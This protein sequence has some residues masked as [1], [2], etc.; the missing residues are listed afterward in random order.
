MEGPS[1]S[2]VFIDTSL[3]THLAM[4]VSGADTVSDLKKKIKVEHKACFPTLGEILVNAVKVKRKGDF[5]HLADSMHVRSAFNGVKKNWFLSVD[6]SISSVYSDGQNMLNPSSSGQPVLL[7]ITSKPSSDRLDTAPDD[8]PETVPRKPIRNEMEM[9]KEKLVFDSKDLSGEPE[10]IVAPDQSI[11]SPKSSEPQQASFTEKPVEPVQEKDIEM[12][13]V[14]SGKEYSGDSAED[15]VHSCPLVVREPDHSKRGFGQN[16]VTGG[17]EKAIV[18]GESVVAS[19][20][21]EL[22]ASTKKRKTSKRLKESDGEKCINSFS[23]HIESSLIGRSLADL[24]KVPEG[25]ESQNKLE[26]RENFLS[27]ARGGETMVMA[28]A[29]PLDMH[30]TKVESSQQVIEKNM[31]I[32]STEEKT[33]KKS[34]KSRRSIV[35]NLPSVEMKDPNSDGNDPLV[36]SVTVN[37]TTNKQTSQRGPVK[38]SSCASEGNS[39]GDPLQLTMNVDLPSNDHL[40]KGENLSEARGGETIGLIA[41]P[42][43]LD[44]H[45][46]KVE[47][48][49]Q[50]IEEEAKTDSIGEKT[51]KKRKKSR[52]S[53]GENL[54]LVEM[55]DPN[56]DAFE[57][58]PMSTTLND[59]TNEHTGIMKPTKAPSHTSEGNNEGGPPQS[60]INVDLPSGD[61]L[62]KG[63][64]NL[65]PARGGEK[66]VRAAAIEPL[67]M[68]GT[69]AESSQQII[70][71]ELNFDCT[72]EKTKKKRKK[73]RR[74]TGKNLPLMETKDPK[75]DAFEPTTMSTTLNDTTNEHTRYMEPMKAPSHTSE[76]NNEG[77]LPQSIIKVDLPSGDPLDKG[78]NK[79]SQARGGET[80]VRAAPVEPLDVHG[81]EAE[82]S[83]Q[84]IEKVN[85]ETAEKKKTKKK[86]KK[87][88][89]SAAE[90]LPSVEMKDP[91]SKTNDPLPISATVDET[92]NGHISYMKP[93]EAPSRTTEGN[94]KGDPAQ[95]IMN[96]DLHSGDHLAKGGNSLSQTRGGET[97]VRAAAV[98]PLDV[99]RTKAESL[100]QFVDKEMN[101]EST[102]ENTN[103]KRKKSPRSTVENLPSV[104]M[105]DPDSDANDPPPIS[106]TMKTMK[107]P[108]HTYEG[109]NEGDLPQ[110]I[111][112]VDIPSGDHLDEVNNH[113][114]A[115]IE[116]DIINFSD[117]FAPRQLQQE[118]LAPD[119]SVVDGGTKENSA[120]RK[121]K[122]KRRKKAD[123]TVDGSLSGLQSSLMSSGPQDGLKSPTGPGST[124]QTLLSS[125][126][127]QFKIIAEEAPGTKVI[128]V[129]PNL[130]ED[131]ET[132]AA[133]G[134][135]LTSI[136]GEVVDTSERKKSLLATS[137]AIFNDESSGSSAEAEG[138]EDS[139]AST[140]T[141]SDKLLSDYSDG[142]SN[143]NLNSPRDGNLSRKDDG[144]S[145]MKKSQSLD[146]KDLTLD[147]ILRSSSRYK[148]AKLAASQSQLGDSESQPLEFQEPP[149]VVTSRGLGDCRQL[150]GRCILGRPEPVS[151]KPAKPEP[152]DHPLGAPHPVDLVERRLEDVEEDPSDGRDEGQQQCEPA[153]VTL[154]QFSD[155]LG[156][157]GRVGM[158]ECREDSPGDGGAG[159]DL[160]RLGEVERRPAGRLRKVGLRDG[161]AGMSLG[162]EEELVAKHLALSM[163]MVDTVAAIG[164]GCF[165]LELSVSLSS[166]GGGEL[167]SWMVMRLR[168]KN[169]K[170]WCQLSTKTWKWPMGS[171]SLDSRLIRRL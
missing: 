106:A 126:S 162:C 82:S 69:K 117:Y 86:R 155:L 81:T 142:D 20:T 136:L 127:D 105:E 43:H 168:S 45:R 121:V 100:E 74:S 35:E 109:K 23:E 144:G 12:R 10:I 153:V 115:V 39:G 145:S 129:T 3:G 166:S 71:K 37:E 15:G 112:D 1:P 101:I 104:D 107:A 76:G 31:D 62:D 167:K 54:P 34:K 60:I 63:E 158:A 16:K 139:N 103:K 6:A 93:M 124:D 50:I 61:H 8:Q 5:Y 113:V 97:M 55:K 19:K 156:C 110:S 169:G 96:V 90:N 171:C 160:G 132:S 141:P 94:N 42:G 59:T 13:D 128:V 137:I 17:I 14:N 89:R 22:K 125:K 9:Q 33:K 58:T 52:R 41:A 51:K 11:Q 99:H 165:E 79:L 95:S 7:A 108:S 111:K 53:T 120:A 135:L 138:I 49:Q 159:Q 140:R 80:I 152:D 119:N 161:F 164:G 29:K 73:S 149:S 133:S 27:Q 88:G 87:S 92:A 83:Q 21:E 102:A 44:V 116:S 26:N 75:S 130:E 78:E 72:E 24:Q 151:D 38:A 134:N 40:E 32:E 131:S 4:L 150:G 30:G 77:G 2:A 170:E 65:S 146:R 85:V 64:G 18:T 147:K 84:I 46:S 70:E 48:S 118:A 66:I 91:K 114:K 154:G 28:A 98:E 157:E 163:A 68:H 143:A 67:D 123:A 47:S 56:S 57:L 122:S 36:T 25:D 148:K